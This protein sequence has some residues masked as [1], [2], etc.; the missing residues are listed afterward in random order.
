MQRKSL[1]PLPNLSRSA[2]WY[3]K[4]ADSCGSPKSFCTRGKID[5]LILTDVYFSPWQT[6][7]LVGTR[8]LL[9]TKRYAVLAR[10]SVCLNCWSRSGY[11]GSRIPIS[12]ASASQAAKQK[13]R[14]FSQSAS[15]SALRLRNSRRT[16]RTR[17]GLGE[18][19]AQRRTRRLEKPNV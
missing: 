3:A 7:N 4:V 6:L 10:A 18:R 2:A 11:S 17:D 1:R 14:G 19:N 13:V 16:H 12:S 8:H 15:H 9:N 5:H